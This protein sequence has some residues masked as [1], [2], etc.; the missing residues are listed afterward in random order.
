MH[1]SISDALV[2]CDALVDLMHLSISDALVD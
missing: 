1:L 2:D